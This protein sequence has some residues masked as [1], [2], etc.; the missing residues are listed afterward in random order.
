MCVDV[1][2][3]AKERLAE[4]VRNTRKNQHL[5][6]RAYGKKLGVTGT[7]VRRWEEMISDPDTENLRRI[8]SSAGI[9]VEDLIT[10]LEGKAPKESPEF[11]KILMQM[12]LLP[13]PQVAAIVKAGVDRL[14]SVSEGH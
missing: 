5:S 2:L 6:Q 4:F 7:A 1:N 11:E 3:E 14:A 10:Y 9:P 13:L 8:A 12:N